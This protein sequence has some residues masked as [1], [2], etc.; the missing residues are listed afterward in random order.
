MTPPRQWTDLTFLN[1]QPPR[2]QDQKQYGIHEA[3]ISFVICGSDNRRWV[4]YGFVDTEFDRENLADHDLSYVGKHEDP[5][6]FGELDANLPIWDPR[7]YFLMVLQI[8]MAQVLK[9]WE[10]LIRTVERSINQ[11]VCRRFLP[12]NQR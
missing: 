12:T 9:E 8:R 7:E 6:A 4:G 2:S 11:Y 10:C 5:I 1:I 3:Q